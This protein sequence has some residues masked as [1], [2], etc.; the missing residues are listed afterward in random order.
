MRRKP[1]SE[2]P[3]VRDPVPLR[4]APNDAKFF[5]LDRQASIAADNSIRR[6][7]DPRTNS[8]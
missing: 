3:E 4:T 7:V 1:D 2:G 8:R 6:Q 5:A